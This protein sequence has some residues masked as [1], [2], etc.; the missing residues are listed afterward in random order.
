MLDEEEE[1]EGELLEVEEKE[2]EGE[3]LVEK[4]EEQYRPRR[5]N[6]S[7]SDE[8]DRNQASTASN[9]K[10]CYRAGIGH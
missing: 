9:S 1:E 4:K 8:L 2:E 6:A 10:L 3:L 5:P 7:S